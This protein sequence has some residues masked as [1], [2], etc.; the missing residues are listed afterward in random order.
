MVITLRVMRKEDVPQVTE[1]D[2]EAFPTMWPA[3]NYERELNSRMSYFIVACDEERSAEPLRLIK[4]PAN[5]RPGLVSGLKRL[6]GHSRLSDSNKPP[7]GQYIIG[8]VGFWVMASE[9]H[10]TS[11]AVREKLRRRGLGELLLIS[12]IDRAMEL[13]VNILTLEV[14]ASNFGAQ[15]LY[16]KYGF[17]KTGMR[18]GYY[19]DN[20]EDGIIMSTDDINTAS[21]QARLQR[22]RQAHSRKWGITS[23]QVAR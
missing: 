7:A 23:Y 5:N 20:R 2:R 19:T 4:H 6:F 21:F 15:T 22:L 18:R 14:R 12:V 8:F 11:I 10:I 3:P 16:L 9:A 1:I 17:N 13:R